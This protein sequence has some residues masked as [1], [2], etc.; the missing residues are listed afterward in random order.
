MDFQFLYQDNSNSS[1][2][3]A[4]NY[5]T[6]FFFSLIIFIFAPNTTGQVIALAYLIL[7]H[8]VIWNLGDKFRLYT[9]PEVFLSSGPWDTFNQRVYWVVGPQFY[10]TLLFTILTCVSFLFFHQSRELD[11]I[12]NTPPMPLPIENITGYQVFDIN[13]N[14]GW[15][16]DAL[17]SAASIK[18]V[19]LTG[20][21]KLEYEVVT[22]RYGDSPDKNLK[23]IQQQ[24]ARNTVYTTQACIDKIIQANAAIWEKVK[25]L[26]E[27]VEIASFNEKDYQNQACANSIVTLPNAGGNNPSPSCQISRKGERVEERS[28]RETVA[29]NP[30]LKNEEFVYTYSSSPSETGVAL[31]ASGD[32][33]KLRDSK[34]KASA[35]PSNSN[36]GEAPSQPENK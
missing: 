35:T 12:A 25:T 9:K 14:T 13:K 22:F 30:C 28:F 34:I 33:W 16:S 31:R 10:S 27:L 5:G 21:T 15:G 4:L 26:P 11:R 17:L 20:G 18:P 6:R 29:E 1:F 8:P 23:K 7:L 32:L 19:V 36:G 3:K 2:A 24:W